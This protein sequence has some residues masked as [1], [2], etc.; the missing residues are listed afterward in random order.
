MN[1][2]ETMVSE[3]R[4][5]IKRTRIPHIKTSKIW[6]RPHEVEDDPRTKIEYEPETIDSSFSVTKDDTDRKGNTTE[7]VDWFSRGEKS[8]HSDNIFIEGDVIYDYGYHFPMAIRM[9]GK[10]AYFN[11][12]GYSVTTAKHKSSLQSALIGEGYTIISSNTE[13]MKL[14][15]RK[16]EYRN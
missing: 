15:I 14:A 13:K 6:P 4:T 11:T 12:D 7:V 8:G 5:K 9:P 3:L 10:K 2:S 16:Q 1:G